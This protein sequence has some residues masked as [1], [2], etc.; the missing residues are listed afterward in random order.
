MPDP[1][2]PEAP[3]QDEARTSEPTAAHTPR[4]AVV[5][6]ER[7]GRGGKEATIIEHL[8]LGDRERAEWIKAL[9]SALGCGGAV[10]GAHLVLQGDQRARVRQWLL[11]RGVRKVTG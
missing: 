5:R 9:K 3:A 10:E 7:A 4:R 2:A 1:P 8:D 11:A 6:L